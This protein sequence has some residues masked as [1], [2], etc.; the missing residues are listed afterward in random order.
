MRAALGGTRSPLPVTGGP[1]SKCR[2]SGSGHGGDSGFAARL[3]L[4]AGPCDAIL[5]GATS[6]W[7][8]AYV[9]GSLFGPIGLFRGPLGW[10]L[11]AAGALWLCH[12]RP[13]IRLPAPSTGQKPALL[14]FAVMA[15]ITL[16][17]QLGSPLVPLADALSWPASAQRILTFH[18]YAPLDTDPYGF[19]DGPRRRRPTLSPRFAS[20]DLLKK[21]LIILGEYVMIKVTL[22]A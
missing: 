9:L 15:L 10:L 1:R 12:L 6:P 20:G 22:E 21:R 14:A 11:L 19:T 13:P 3:R 7:L 17:V 4:G 16:P 8:L 5:A 2:C 18:T